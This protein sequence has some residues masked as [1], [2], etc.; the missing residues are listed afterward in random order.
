MRRAFAAVWRTHLSLRD[1]LISRLWRS[2]RVGS[3]PG[4]RSSSRPAARSDDGVRSRGVWRVGFAPRHLSTPPRREG[5]A[6]PRGVASL[7]RPAT[8]MHPT[9]P[10][11]AHRPGGV[12]NN[13]R[14]A[15]IFRLTPRPVARPQL[16]HAP[17]STRQRRHRSQPQP[18]KAK[19][20]SKR[21]PPPAAMPTHGAGRANAPRPR[22][23]PR[24]SAG[25]GPVGLAAERRRPVPAEHRARVVGAADAD[26]LEGRVQQVAPVQR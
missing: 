8:P 24:P 17:A 2:R 18:V 7:L 16:T 12:A 10:P 14:P 21:A 5:R 1:G 3:A 15:G 19:S 25:Q 6:S 20:R 22:P 13:P 23:R 11:E 4:S 9:P 26:D